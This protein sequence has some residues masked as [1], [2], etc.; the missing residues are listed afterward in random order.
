MAT[1]TAIR[2]GLATA[3]TAA[4]QNA[5]CSGYVLANP[6]TPAFDIYLGETYYDQAA[7]RGLD[8]WSMRVRA[9]VADSLDIG[10]QQLL[11]SFCAPSGAQSVKAA[12]EADL[13]LGGVVDALQVT[14]LSGYR[15][16]SA[17]NRNDIFYMSAEW[18]VEVWAAA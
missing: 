7:N 5:Q 8:R 6:Q 14:G 11:D 3:L 16:V 18:T 17:F 10:S 15:K 9:L 2:A 4:I 12:L 1:L 13:T